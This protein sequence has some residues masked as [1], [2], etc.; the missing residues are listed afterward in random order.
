MRSRFSVS[1]FALLLLACGPERLEKTEAD[2]QQAVAEA[3][4]RGDTAT[5]WLFIEVPFAFDSFYIAGPRTP[6]AQIADVFKSEDWIPEFTRD[7]ENQDGFHLLLFEAKGK[8][9]PATL[10]KSVADFD[11][12]LV[13]RMY[14]PDDR[15]RL[16][17]A[18][19]PGAGAPMI[20]AL[21]ETPAP[22]ASSP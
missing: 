10:L 8:L 12:A 14:R 2:L 5:L 19:G 6:A 4:T 1:L 7:I 9:I 20:V 15:F 13:G 16:R 21:Q 11:P 22:A 3:L 17:R 18:S